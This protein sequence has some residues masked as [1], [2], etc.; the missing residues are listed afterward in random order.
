MNQD[1]LQPSH[2]FTISV[3]KQR[4]EKFEAM[5][6][7]LSKQ[8]YLFTKIN[9]ENKALTLVSIKVAYLLMKAGKP[10]MDG[11]IIKECMME[12]VGELCPEKLKLSKQLLSLFRY[13]VP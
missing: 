4:T 1:M 11:N 13:L 9:S 3:R 6:R 12:A 8:Q 5:R 2:N 7:S 10:F